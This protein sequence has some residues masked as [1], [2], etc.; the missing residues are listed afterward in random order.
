LIWS[1]QIFGNTLTEVDD[2]VDTIY[3]A[4]ETKLGNQFSKVKVGTLLFDGQ[5]VARELSVSF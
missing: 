4:Y 2:S 1:G 5:R 3:D